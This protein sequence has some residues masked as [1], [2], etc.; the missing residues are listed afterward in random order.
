MLEDDRWC[1]E[2]ARHTRK[3]E[4]DWAA[5]IARKADYYFT[6]QQARRY[7][8]VDHIVEERS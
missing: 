2:M 4:E 5:W 6:A 7:G 8:V 3:P 1:Q